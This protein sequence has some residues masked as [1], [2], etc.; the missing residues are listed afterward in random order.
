MNTLPNPTGLLLFFP[1]AKNRINL[2]K[3]LLQKKVRHNE[4]N[5]PK[6]KL[7]EFSGFT[8]IK[9]PSKNLIFNPKTMKTG[10]AT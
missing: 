9:L 10:N 8:N 7:I 6:P 1:T 4:V 5:Q 3:K 2:Q